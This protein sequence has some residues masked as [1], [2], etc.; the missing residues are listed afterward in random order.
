MH[1]ETVEI[2]TEEYTRLTQGTEFQRHTNFL[3]MM[4]QVADEMAVDAL[5]AMGIHGEIRKR[6][7]ADTRSNAI[8]DFKRNPPPGIDP[9]AL[10]AFCD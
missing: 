7:L 5:D 10:A 2:T 1:S 4:L 6:L 9:D 3:A 8:A